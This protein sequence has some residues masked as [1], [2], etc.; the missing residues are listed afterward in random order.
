MGVPKSCQL[1]AA[2]TPVADARS[3]IINICLGGAVCHLHPKL[4]RL[5]QLEATT[6]VSALVTLIVFL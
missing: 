3:H 1:S 4:V 6:L 2:L 5:V